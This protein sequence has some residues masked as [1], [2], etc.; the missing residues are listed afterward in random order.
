MSYDFIDEL[1][2]IGAL[3]QGHFVLASGRHSDQYVEKFDLLRN[4]RAT[5][6]ACSELIKLLGR[7]AEVDLIVGPT[8]GGILLAFE[9]GRQLG[10]PAAYAERKEEG[11]PEREFK[12]GTYIAPGTRVLVVDDVMTTGGSIRATLDAVK[13]VG[14]EAVAVAL[15]VDRAG[16]SVTFDVPTRPLASLEISSWP[17]DEVPEWL[18]DVPVTK[19]GTTAVEAESD[20]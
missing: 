1:K 11:S 8:T 5:E 2:Q 17:A 3:K 20:R 12:R 10:L 15:L 14:A 6:K 19:P 18:E 13:D 16:G 4:P 9:I 7:F